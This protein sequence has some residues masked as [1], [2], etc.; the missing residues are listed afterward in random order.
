[1]APRMQIKPQMAST[2]FPILSLPGEVVMA[3]TLL[4]PF[5]GVNATYYNILIS[6]PPATN[7][8]GRAARIGLQNR[9]ALACG[10]APR[11]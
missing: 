11:G 1:L 9:H 10:A 4:R 2:V 3:T 5:D 6:S 8:S 7:S